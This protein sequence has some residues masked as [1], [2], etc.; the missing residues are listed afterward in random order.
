M[1]MTPGWTG[2]QYSLARGILALIVACAAWGQLSTDSPLVVALAILGLI[3]AALLL[4][5]WQDRWAA[6][7]L[8]GLAF[9]GA[10]NHTSLE[11]ALPAGI[12]ALVLLVHATQPAHP[13]GSWAAR[14][15]PDPAGGWRF[16]TQLFVSLWFI[17]AVAYGGMGIAM[18]LDTEQGWR[19]GDGLANLLAAEDRAV[20]LPQMLAAGTWLILALHLAFAPLALVGRLR[21]WLWGSMVIVNIALAASLDLQAF[22]LGLLPLHLF[23]FDPGWIRPLPRRGRTE[24]PPPWSPRA[25]E[26]ETIFYDGYCGLC[27]RWVRFVLSEDRTGN[28]FAFAP[29]QSPAF[30]KAVPASQRADLPDSVV[31][32][33][34][35]GRLL[36]RSDAVIYLCKRL[37]G[38]W[39]PIGALM[40]WL[41]RF[42]R[43]G[44]YNAVAAVRHRLFTRPKEACPMLPPTLRSRFHF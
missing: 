1:T 34:A 37:G 16:R 18:L 9:A 5:G 36:T 20:A 30:E 3:G 13:Y 22:R 40:Q 28:T 25:D 7:L 42:I 32:Q 2:A 12:L 27:H 31:V 11:A 19:M 26:P 38:I 21:S 14:G 43:D 17:M 35:D 23:T 8:A 10:W 33:R 4:L 41:P 39:R 24:Q 29:L 44:I 15:R 6:L